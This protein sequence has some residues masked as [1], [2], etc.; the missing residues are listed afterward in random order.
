MNTP[1]IQCVPPHPEFPSADRVACF[2]C[3]DVLIAAASS[4]RMIEVGEALAVCVL[5]AQ[6]VPF[7]MLV[8][9]AELRKEHGSRAEKN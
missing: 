4:F 8:P 1:W 3:G 6:T 5:C 7:V 9:T 2:K